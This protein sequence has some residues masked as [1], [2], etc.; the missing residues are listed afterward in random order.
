MT[1]SCRVLAQMA[2]DCAH[3]GVKKE[4]HVARGERRDGG[5]FLVAQT[6]L[7][8]EIDDFALIAGERLEHV[9]DSAKG[10]ARVVLSVEVVDDRHLGVRQ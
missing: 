4:P 3:G 1:G 2:A 10:P 8:L 7:K 5:D 6:T 9:E